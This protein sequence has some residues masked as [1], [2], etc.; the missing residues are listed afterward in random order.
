MRMTPKRYVKVVRK[1]IH[2]KARV[3][4]NVDRQRTLPSFFAEC[5]ARSLVMRFFSQLEKPSTGAG[6]ILRIG[7]A[8]AAPQSIPPRRCLSPMGISRRF[9]TVHTQKG[10]VAMLGRKNPSD[11]GEIGF[12]RT[13]HSSAQFLGR[14]M[15]G[16]QPCLR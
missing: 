5:V 11:P 2:L 1:A 6:M 12:W 16:S 14:Q 8:L 4:G 13:V 15:V 3:W 10:W 9:A 7:F